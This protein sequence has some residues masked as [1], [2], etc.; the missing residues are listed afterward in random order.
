MLDS[1]FKAWFL[2]P[3]MDPRLRGDDTKI[4][5]FELNNYMIHFIK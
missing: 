2:L 5:I 3:N 1:K 4:Y